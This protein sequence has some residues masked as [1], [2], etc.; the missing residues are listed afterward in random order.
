MFNKDGE[1]LTGTF[2][3]ST[4]ETMLTGRS[5]ETNNAEGGPKFAG[6]V[7][8]GPNGPRVPRPKGRI[9][10][11][12]VCYCGSGQKYKKCCEKFD[13]EQSDLESDSE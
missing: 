4:M 7:Y 5:F 3:T 12:D 2:T 10:R 6:I 9:G 13:A 1:R 8:N 11:N